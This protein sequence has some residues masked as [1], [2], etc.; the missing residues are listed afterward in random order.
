M[1]S[2][3]FRPFADQQIM[4]IGDV[5]IDAYMWG[6]VT[7]ISPEAPVPVVAIHRRE[8]RLG[9][10]AN[11]AL[12]L[13]AL[14]CT[15]IVC[16]VL[17]NDDAGRDCLQLMYA[18]NI[19]RRGIVQ[20][21]DRMTTVKSRV[22]GNNSHIVRVDEETT[23][24]LSESDATDLIVR[25]DVTLRTSH[26]DAIIFQDYDK[27]CITPQIIDEVTAMAKRRD[28]L[29]TVDPKHRNFLHYHDVSLF[30]PNLKELREGLNIDVEDHTPEALKASLDRAAALLHER[31]HIERVCI[32]LSNRGLYACDFR[33]SPAQSFLLPA[34]L[35]TIADV[36]GAG[37]TVI[38]V[39]TSLLASGVD[40]PDA[41]HA[42]NMAGGIVCEQVGVVPIDRARL[43]S[44][45]SKENPALWHR[46]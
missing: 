25:V 29:T 4:I 8:K 40:L 20:S 21:Y 33:T 12:N 18:H 24:P 39:A 7:R 15:P 30:K 26:I 46:D 32:T 38:S 22:I 10:A 35:R 3:T 1:N 14:G 11:V 27:G 23:S 45:L 13:L 44:E 42:A 36:S 37:D 34:Q 6:E 28:I 5:M 31:Q 17:G 16:T 41:M 2:D 19:D 43:L 9:G